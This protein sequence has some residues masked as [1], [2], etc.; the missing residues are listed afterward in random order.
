MKAPRATRLAERVLSPL[1]GKS[2]VVY[3]VKPVPA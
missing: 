3:L 2:I 1:I